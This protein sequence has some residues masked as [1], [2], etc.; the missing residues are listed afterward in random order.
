M[1]ATLQSKSKKRKI[2][3][4]DNCAPRN[5]PARKKRKSAPAHQQFFIL[6]DPLFNTRASRP[7]SATGEL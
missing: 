7:S 1:D 3:T 4:V 6:V 2:M 5:V